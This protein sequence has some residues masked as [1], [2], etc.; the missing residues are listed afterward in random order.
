MRE[1]SLCSLHLL[2]EWHP[3]GRSDAEGTH[4]AP[5]PGLVPGPGFGPAPGRVCDD[6]PMGRLLLLF[7]LVP[8]VELALLI[9]LGRHIGTLNTIA[10]I[11]VT[12]IAGAALTRRQGLQ[13]IRSVQRDL[14]EGRLPASSLVDGV[15]ILMAGA[16]L[17]TPGVLTDAFGFLCLV[18]G[19]RSLA[20]RTLM[21][22]LERAT[23]E[24]RVHVVTQDRYY[25]MNDDTRR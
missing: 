4:I 9:E 17:I 1:L 24:G 3:A 11:A 13:V 14:A 2:K 25:D 15:I 23:S 22:R 20:K 7:I 10:L 21:R 19:F 5:P 6:A 8:A 12:G 18:P 16:L